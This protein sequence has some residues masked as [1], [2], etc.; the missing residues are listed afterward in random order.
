MLCVPTCAQYENV[1]HSLFTCQK[2]LRLSGTDYFKYYKMTALLQFI[3]SETSSIHINLLLGKKYLINLNCYL[4][5]VTFIY[6]DILKLIK[7]T[8]LRNSNIFPSY[9]SESIIIYDTTSKRFKKYIFIKAGK[10]TR[11]NYLYVYLLFF[12]EVVKLNYIK[13]YYII[14]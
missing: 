12:T 3:V 1:E 5:K 4:K 9:K 13:I 7:N 6:K 14:L 11:Y 10:H 2:Y 8:I